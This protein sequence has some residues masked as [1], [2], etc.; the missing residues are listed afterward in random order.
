MVRWDRHDIAWFCSNPVEGEGN[1]TNTVCDVV[2]QPVK[3][4]SLADGL[5]RRD[6]AE[7]GLRVK[8]SL[9]ILN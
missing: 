1:T 8:R 7:I 4:P 2:G 9:T 3:P 5:R 6:R